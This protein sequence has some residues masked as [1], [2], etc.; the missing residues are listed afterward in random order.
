MANELP[1]TREEAEREM[2]VVVVTTE[3]PI[4]QLEKEMNAV[5]LRGEMGADG[6]LTPHMLPTTA[7]FCVNVWNCRGVIIIGESDIH[8]DFDYDAQLY[9]ELVQTVVYDDNDGAINWSG[10]YYPRTYKTARLFKK[11]LKTLKVKEDKIA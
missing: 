5:F 11:F 9:D 6:K 10:R 2:G 8:D 7:D 4:R 1:Q 3:K